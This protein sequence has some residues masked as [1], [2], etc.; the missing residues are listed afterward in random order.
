M[1][2]RFRIFMLFSTGGAIIGGIPAAL[3]SQIPEK[4]LSRD[5][6]CHEQQATLASRRSGPEYLN[7]ISNVQSCRSSA[8][9]SLI[10]QWNRRQTD[11]AVLELLGRVSPLIRDQELFEVTVQ[12]ARDA[13]RPR[14]ERLSA[15]TALAG[16]A[17]PTV[18]ISFHRLDEAGLTGFSYVWLG[19]TSAVLT[20]GVTP[21][22]S[23]T[24]NRVLQIFSDVADD[25]TD[26]TIQAIASFL[27]KEL[28]R[29]GT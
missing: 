4:V 11:S 10:A 29:M 27:S 2:T 19:R 18:S 20:P 13:K 22:R 26:Q 17:D 1:S 14:N 3:E 5:E 6:Y 12:I 8:A 15:F 21:L 24:R 25:P 9:K 16:Y 23:D 7:A 28:L